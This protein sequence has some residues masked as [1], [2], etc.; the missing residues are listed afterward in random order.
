MG[1]LPVGR[2]ET[3]GKGRVDGGQQVSRLLSFA[4]FGPQTGK[5]TCRAQLEGQRTLLARDGERAPQVGSGN[6]VRAPIGAQQQQRPLALEFGG[7]GHVVAQRQGLES[8][9]DARHQRRR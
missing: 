3:L 4:P 2:V 9:A 6:I 5:V 8:P 7:E 1:I